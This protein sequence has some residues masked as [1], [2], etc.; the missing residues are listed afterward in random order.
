MSLFLII[1]LVIE[2]LGFAVAQLLL[3]KGMLITGPLDVSFANLGQ[4]FFTLI[5][6]GYLWAGG[7]MLI[8]SFSLWLYLISRINLNVIYAVSASLTLIAVVV[9][10]FFL[11]KEN[12]NFLQIVGIFVIVIGIFLVLGK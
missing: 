2:A 1:L 7:S 11:F 6:N 5:K 3:K 9:I 10:S 12:L 8:I 4:L